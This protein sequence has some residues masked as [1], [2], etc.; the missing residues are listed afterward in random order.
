MHSFPPLP[1]IHLPPLTSSLSV[2]NPFS[3]QNIS[4]CQFFY[5]V[6]TSSAISLIAF[7]TVLFALFFI[8]LHLLLFSSVLFQHISLCASFFLDT[9][10]FTSS[11]NRHLFPLHLFPLF[12]PHTS[13]HAFKT[14]SLKWSPHVW[15]SNI[16]RFDYF[17]F[18]LFPDL[19][20]FQRTY[21]SLSAC[22]SHYISY[23]LLSIS[24]TT[25]A[26]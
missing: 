20:I 25:K 3:D 5:S 11:F 14:P 15:Q 8:L 12:F 16:N 19:H 1:L 6:S 26:Y 18:K 21:F 22:L 2:F 10:S 23:F 7:E 4:F 24:V 9:A 13:S 17:F